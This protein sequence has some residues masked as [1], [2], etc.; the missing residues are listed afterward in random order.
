MSSSSPS[1]V[2]AHDSDE[3]KHG[4]CISSCSSS[5]SGKSHESIF[6]TEGG[7]GYE[8]DAD[9]ISTAASDGELSS[10]RNLG[11]VVQPLCHNRRS[12]GG[13]GSK[14]KGKRVRK[15]WKW[16][17]PSRRRHH[18]SRCGPTESRGSA[19]PLDSTRVLPSHA[20][21]LRPRQAPLV[22]SIV[23]TSLVSHLTSAQFDSVAASPAS[24]P[25]WELPSHVKQSRLLE[26][27]ATPLSL[28]SSQTVYPRSV[29]LVDPNTADQQ[30]TANMTVHVASQP[31]AMEQALAL[32]TKPHVLLEATAPH[33]V[34]HANAAFGR[35]VQAAT[36]AA[37]TTTAAAAAAVSDAT[38]TPLCS[39]Q[40]N[41][42]TPPSSSSPPTTVWSQIQA[43]FGPH[44]TVTLYP[45][46][47]MVVVAS[48]GSKSDSLA[49]AFQPR[50]YLVEVESLAPALP[51]AA[52]SQLA[53]NATAAAPTTTTTAPLQASRATIFS[54]NQPA[55]A[56]A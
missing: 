37:A 2:S 40:P 46:G 14:W 32:S 21:S 11:V 54:W 17:V 28:L 41:A 7:R 56:V 48:S 34:W 19:A 26:P 5:I 35:L 55:L 13:G 16:Q 4:D 29:V 52:A 51:L 31:L 44:C 53:A 22:A 47:T 39:S 3:E 24:Y 42:P 6:R 18:N 10:Y 38:Q 23:D 50:H 45:V 49:S 43:T 15:A 30:H 33:R 12:G 9:D 27:Y 1:V 20:P 36:A 8:A 25:R